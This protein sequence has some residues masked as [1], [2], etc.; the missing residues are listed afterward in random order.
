VAH[1]G[2]ALMA[3]PPPLQVPAPD[4]ND[5]VEPFLRPLARPGEPIPS[6]APRGP[7]HTLIA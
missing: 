7:P 1:F 3:A 6:P 2:L 4:R 5:A